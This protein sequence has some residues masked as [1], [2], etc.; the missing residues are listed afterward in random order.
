MN[1]CRAS[2]YIGL[3][4]VKPAQ[5]MDDSSIDDLDFHDDIMDSFDYCFGGLLTNDAFSIGIGLERAG[6]T[7]PIRLL[8]TLDSS[9]KTRNKKDR[10]GL[11]CCI[12]DAQVNSFRGKRRSTA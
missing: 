8:H 2:P 9:A 5:T 7:G 11:A 12:S 1:G 4:I 6:F 3:L 10:R